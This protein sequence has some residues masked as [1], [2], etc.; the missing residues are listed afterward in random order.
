MPFY[1]LLTTNVFVLF[2]ILK[3]INVIKSEDLMIQIFINLQRDLANTM[4]VQLNLHLKMAIAV[5]Y[6]H[7]NINGLDVSK[8]GGCFLSKNTSI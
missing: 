1:E 7:Q 4:N 6:S 8:Y 5:V 2:T 3:A